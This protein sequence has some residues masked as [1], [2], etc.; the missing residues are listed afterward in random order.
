MLRRFAALALARPGPA[1]RSLPAPPRP[2]SSP[3]VRATRAQEGG[4][5]SVGAVFAMGDMAPAPAPG[6]VG[7]RERL[8]RATEYVERAAAGARYYL[9][10]TTESG[11]MVATELLPDGSAAFMAGEELAAR[12]AQ[13]KALR[14]AGCREGYTVDQL[15]I[16]LAG[17]APGSPSSSTRKRFVQATF[18]RL[19]GSA[20]R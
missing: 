8:V 18:Q 10:A 16:L 19:V 6:A 2:S 17:L 14:S 11:A 1:R 15:R 13:A 20:E 9:L 5:L 7:G 4:R 3:E 12:N